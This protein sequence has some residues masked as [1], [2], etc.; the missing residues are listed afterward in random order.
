MSIGSHSNQSCANS[1]TLMPPQF[2]F[3]VKKRSKNHPVV[4]FQ[5]RKGLPLRPIL[6]HCSHSTATQVEVHL[7]GPCLYSRASSL[8]SGP[9][10]FPFIKGNDRGPDLRDEFDPVAIIHLSAT[11]PLE[12]HS[13]QFSATETEFSTNH[14]NGLHICQWTSTPTTPLSLLS[15]H[16]H[17]SRGSFD[18]TLSL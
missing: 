13:D 18:G 6:C 16:C 17:S 14:A 5:Y 10:S 4:H 11:S 15:L 1:T 9:R 3:I 2:Y 8:G 7:M 12:C